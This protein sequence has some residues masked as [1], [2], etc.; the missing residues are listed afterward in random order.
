M[1]LNDVEA[2]KCACHFGSAQTIP[3]CFAV[4]LV[5]RHEHRASFVVF[6][7]SAWVSDHAPSEV[8]VCGRDRCWLEIFKLSKVEELYA[9]IPVR[10][11][12]SSSS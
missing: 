8:R 5:T 12:S 9:Q 3:S 6:S 11:P 7:A 2:S 1:L 10:A 4:T